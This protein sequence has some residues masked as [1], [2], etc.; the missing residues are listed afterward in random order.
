MPL[1]SKAKSTEAQLQ[2]GHVYTLEKSFFY[3]QSRYSSDLKE[4]GFEQEKLST[5]GGNANFKIQVVEAD[6][7]SFKVIATSV[8]DF[9]GDGVF[10][11][12][13]IN[14]EKQLKE[15]TPD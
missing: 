6:N 14:Q 15:V 13:E 8:V 4:I 9:D 11:V 3:M 2:L 5:E 10:N 12:W 1:I 7:N